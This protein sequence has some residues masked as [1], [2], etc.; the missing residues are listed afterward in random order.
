MGA[1]SQ[2]QVI[3]TIGL[4]V[5]NLYGCFFDVDGESLLERLIGLTRLSQ[6]RNLP[7][8]FQ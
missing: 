2:K 3:K 8:L 4:Q 6:E 5:T 7:I 1:T